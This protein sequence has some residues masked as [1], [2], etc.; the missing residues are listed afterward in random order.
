MPPFLPPSSQESSIGATRSCTNPSTSFSSTD[1]QKGL[2]AGCNNTSPSLLIAFGSAPAFNNA[3]PAERFTALV[4]QRRAVFPR[5]HVAFKASS[6]KWYSLRISRY[7]S[8]LE[9][10]HIARHAVCRA[11]AASVRQPTTHS[12]KHMGEVWLRQTIYSPEWPQYFEGARSSQVH[13][14]VM[15]DVRVT[16]VGGL[17]DLPTT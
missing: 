9:L 6:N 16:I 2:V 11:S 7:V 10:P 13:W 3:V 14:A 5:L 4:A 15:P 8:M 12:S 1:G 17:A